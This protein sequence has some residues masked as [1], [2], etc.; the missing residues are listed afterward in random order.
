MKQVRFKPGLKGA[1][2]DKS[3]ESTEENDATGA[4]RGE[5]ETKRQG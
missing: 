5:S 2:D 1:M 4:R 3:G